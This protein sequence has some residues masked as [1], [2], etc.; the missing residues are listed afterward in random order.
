MKQFEENVEAFKSFITTEYNDLLKR[1]KALDQTNVFLQDRCNQLKVESRD[2]L[3]LKNQFSDLT[4]QCHVLTTES[5]VRLKNHR[6]VQDELTEAKQLN[7]NQFKIITNLQK[8]ITLQKSL[9]NSVPNTTVEYLRDKLRKQSIEYGTLIRNNITT[10]SEN[11]RLKKENEYLKAVNEGL[12]KF[13]DTTGYKVTVIPMDGVNASK[14]L[15]KK[16][17]NSKYTVKEVKTPLRDAKGK[18][19]KK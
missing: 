19:I 18:F 2:L 11:V 7:A 17:L 9:I 5:H 12:I 15:M 16:L 10:V 8:Q 3:K 6:R 13:V 14:D 1:N 4:D